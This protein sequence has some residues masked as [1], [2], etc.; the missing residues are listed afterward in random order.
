MC[1]QLT[2]SRLRAEP[3]NF[4]LELM[5]ECMRHPRFLRQMLNEL[6]QLCIGV[7]LVARY[8]VVPTCRASKH[9]AAIFAAQ[10]YTSVPGIHRQFFFSQRS[11][12]DGEAYPPL[13]VLALSR[14]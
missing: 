4:V 5:D 7:N 3:V 12:S 10:N 8:A 1:A 11:P 14:R 6:L 2:I 9:Q 13:Q